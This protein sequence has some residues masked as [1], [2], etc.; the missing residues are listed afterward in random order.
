MSVMQALAGGSGS[1]LSGKVIWITNND[2]ARS[3]SLKE[4]FEKQGSRVEVVKHPKQIADR[5]MHGERPALIVSDWHFTDNAKATEPALPAKPIEE[6]GEIWKNVRLSASA[7]ERREAAAGHLITEAIRNNRVKG[8][9]AIR[10]IMLMK[11]I[12][13][14]SQLFPSNIKRILE[15]TPDTVIVNEA[16][17]A[18]SELLIG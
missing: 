5:I 14:D 13:G 1:A 6:G 17:E 11:G 12:S 15:S 3:Q 18:I 9:P 8:E 7:S 4:K 2:P 10:V 16:R